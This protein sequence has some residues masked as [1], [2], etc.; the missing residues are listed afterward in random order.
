MIALQPGEKQIY[1][2]SDGQK[3]VLSIAFLLLT[4]FVISMPILFLKRS[5]HGLW[6]D[7]L[8]AAIIGAAVLFWGAFLFVQVMSSIRTRIAFGEKML[9]LRVPTWRGP[10]PGVRFIKRRIPYED[11]ASVETRGEVYTALNA[12]KIPVLTRATSVVTKDGE[13]IV[14]GYRNE[15]DED[16]ELDY[17]RIAAQIAARAGVNL[18]DRGRVVAGNHL[19]AYR[20]GEIPKWEAPALTEDEYGALRAKSNWFVAGLTFGVLILFALGLAYDFYRSGFLA[21]LLGP[22]G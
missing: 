18:I 8:S 4:P 11:I 6:A 16:P 7:A 2:T 20:R 22:A 5:L 21:N 13:R 19:T 3:A 1:E 17:P 10:N 15:D 14:L 12:L 9:N